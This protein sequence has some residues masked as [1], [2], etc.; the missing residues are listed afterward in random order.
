M[1]RDC[2]NCENG[3]GMARFEDETFTLDHAGMNQTLSGLSG[4][5][6]GTCGEVAFD[7]DSAG[8]YAAAGDAL[9]LRERQRQSKE[10]AHP[11]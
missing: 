5:R 9:V 10:P 1:T 6:C 2:L 7:P 3:D 4:W 11:A 8:R